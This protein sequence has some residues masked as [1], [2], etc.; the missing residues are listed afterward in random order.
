MIKGAQLRILPDNIKAWSALTICAYS[1]AM[2]VDWDDAEMEK[3]V[4]EL[5]EELC[6]TINYCYS[7]NDFDLRD[8]CTLEEDKWD[9]LNMNW[10]L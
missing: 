3:D 4:F 5:I 7:D 6:D 1:H 8:A 10:D 9:Y 2:T